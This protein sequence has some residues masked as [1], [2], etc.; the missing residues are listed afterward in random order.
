MLKKQSYKKK[1]IKS[2]RS[3]NTLRQTTMKTWPDKMWDAAKVTLRG[4]VHS[5]TSLPQEMRKISD[6]LTYHLK[7]LK[8]RRT[9]TTKS[10]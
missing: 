5:D 1:V 4:K 9:T 6:N 10:K 2:K 8:R 7:E 3:E